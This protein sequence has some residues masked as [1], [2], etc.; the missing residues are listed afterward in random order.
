MI[1]WIRC[2]QHPAHR[3]LGQEQRAAQIDLHHRVEI[4]G[5]QIQGIAAQR[6][7]DAGICHEA[8]EPAEPFLDPVQ[9]GLMG[10]EIGDVEGLEGGLSAMAGDR[11]TG[12]LGLLVP[13]EVG[14][15]Q[16]IAGGGEGYGDGAAD[17]ALGPGD[18]GDGPAHA[19]RSWRRICSA[20]R[21]ACAAM[22]SAGLTAAELGRK[23]GIDDEEIGVV[24]G[25]A[26]G[27]ERRRRGIAPEAHRAALM[28]G[29]ALVEGACVSTIGKP[30]ARKISRIAGDEPAWARQLV[31]C[32]SSRI[33]PPSS[34]TR[35]SGLGAGP[36]SSDTSR[37]AWRLIRFSRNSGTRRRLPFRIAP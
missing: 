21:S 16:I 13:L 28:R 26:V 22:V 30:A 25:A 3:L 37:R 5:L 15:H 34:L 24:P 33:C 18:E 2:G 12:R 19:R 27:V 8:V 36:R 1:R 11:R 10:G 35:L 29:G 7:A 4:I 31:R 9:R 6:R 20:L 14:Q 32:Q 17:T 23:P